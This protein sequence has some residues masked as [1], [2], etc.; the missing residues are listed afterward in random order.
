MCYSAQIWADYR[1]YVRRYGAKID[2]KTFTELFW[3]RSKD[4][5]IK[6]PKAMAAAFDDPK[7]PEEA[8]VARLIAEFDQQETMKLEQER[9]AQT[10]RKADAERVLQ[11]KTTKKALEDL[12]ISTDKIDK[13]KYNLE[14]LRRGDLKPRDSRI[15]PAWYAPVMVMENGQRIVKAMR[16]QCRPAGMPASSDFTKDRSR[17]G[18]YNARRD[19]LERFWRRQFGYTHGIVV[20]DAFYENVD[21]D[22][23][24]AV[25]EFRPNNG[26]DMLVAC[27][28]SHWTGE[29]EDDLLSFAAITDV[30]PPEVAAAGHDR[31]IIPIKPENVDAWLNP[32][33]ANLAAL[34]AIL[35]D[36]DRPYYEHRLAA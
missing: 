12:R 30:P 24:N 10:K 7:S 21:R 18:T 35:D 17:S 34:H 20:A 28:W 6:V 22:G 11:T 27:L 9:F 23:K 2:I 26:Q 36:R 4:K 25:L 8:E 5:K 14:E 3:Y 29:G 13:A 19:N 16:Y 33:P 15:Y 31:C 1:K 32:D